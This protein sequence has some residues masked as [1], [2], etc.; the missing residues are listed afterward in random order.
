MDK[1]IFQMKEY[2]NEIKKTYKQ[3][4]Q[5]IYKKTK[6]YYIAKD[7]NKNRLYICY[8]NFLCLDIDNDTL[9]PLKEFCKQNKDYLFQIY[10]TRK[11][12]HAFCMSH[13]FDAKKYK[14]QLFM[15]QMNCDPMYV[16]FSKL[17]DFSIRLSHKKGEVLNLPIYKKTITIGSGK[18]LPLLKSLLEVHDKLVL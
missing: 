1:L 15:L 14:T 16:A 6:D 10:K 12:Y 17:R 7:I 18:A 2:Y 13:R 9:K 3:S 5:Q 8:K 11:G 4:N